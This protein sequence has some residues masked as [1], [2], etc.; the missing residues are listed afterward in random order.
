M[1]LIDNFSQVVAQI[2]SERGVSRD[3]LAEAIEQA[4]VAACR[5]KF[6]E[7]AILEAVLDRDTGEATIFQVKTVVETVYDD[8]LEITLADAQKMHPQAELDQDLRFDV[9]PRDFGRIAAQTAKQVIVQRIREAEKNVIYEEY[10]DRMG[11]ILVGSVQRVE[12]KNYLINLGRAEAILYPKDQIPGER[13]TAKEKVRVYISDVE[14]GVRGTVIHISRS[15]SGFLRRLFE[16]E[17]PEINDGVIEI[18][19]VSRDPGRRSKV[20]V[21]SHNPSVGA[22]GTCVGHMG[23]RIQSVIKELGYEKIDVLEWSENPRI[24]IANALKPAKISQVMITDEAERMA[25]VVVAAD[26]LSLAIGKAGV[27]VKLAVRLTGWRLDIL[28]EEEYAQKADT[29]HDQ[30]L[31]VVEKTKKDKETPEEAP[32]VVPDVNDV[33]VGDDHQL[34]ATELAKILKMKTQDMIDKAKSFGI[35]IESSRSVLTP[36]QVNTIKEKI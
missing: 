21:R 26:Q 12:N 33:E 8:Y 31:S 29:I 32:F 30:V 15:D 36:E 9:T 3:V 27:N 6:D 4:L 16:L 14:K 2:E 5:K 11:E 7:D 18:V 34:K 23:G 20:A 19:G 35:E 28:S 22:V 13:F 25:T 10:K 1:I 24:F 17:I